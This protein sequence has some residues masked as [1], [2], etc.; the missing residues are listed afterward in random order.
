MKRT[1]V[2][3]LVRNLY[4]GNQSK[5]KTL[6]IAQTRTKHSELHAS[7]WRRDR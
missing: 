5:L 1:L 2:K 7:V 3:R 4:F 6:Q